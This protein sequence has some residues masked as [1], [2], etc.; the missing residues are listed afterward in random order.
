MSTQPIPF[1]RIL[2]GPGPSTVAPRVLEALSRAPLGH[3]DPELFPVLDEIQAGLRMVFGTNNSFTIANTGTGMAGVGGCISNLIEPGDQGLIGGR[4][5]F[6]GRICEIGPPYC[7]KANPGA[8]QTGK[9][10]GTES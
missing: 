7:P 5:H 10:P 8:A 4:R 1:P 3:L 6:W 9:P 2:M